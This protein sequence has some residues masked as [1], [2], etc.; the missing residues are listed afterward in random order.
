MELQNNKRKLFDN[1]GY[2]L[3]EL[4][5]TIGII[6]VLTG[7]SFVTLSLLSSA[8]AK[9]AAVDFDSEISDLAG[10][11]KS[12]QVKILG[13]EAGYQN[14]CFCVKLYK[15]GDKYYVKKGYYN[16]AV[17]NGTE[18]V[19]KEGDT[20]STNV[21]YIFVEGENGKDEKGR[22]FSS[23]VV[24]KYD[25]PDVGIT[26]VPEADITDAG[27]YIV[28]NRSGRCIAGTGEY[29]FYKANGSNICNVTINKN[30]SHQSK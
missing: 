5:I 18:Q 20:V 9:E 26:V 29:R 7:L 8:R 21:Q 6:V 14:F 3:T 27:V 10:R 19:V 24:I 11:A 15:D 13:K 25:A 16:P 1:K 28:Y 30:G 23:K 12:K 17:S 2:S 4:I 22:G